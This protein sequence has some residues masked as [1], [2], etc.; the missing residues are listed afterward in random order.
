M[1]R[2]LLFSGFLLLG[3]LPAGA[4]D[5]SPGAQVRKE[6]VPGITNF[7]E[8]AGTV[9]C[10]GAV[11]PAAVAEVKKRGFKS[12]LDLR[13]AS[14]P[15]A[16]IEAESAAARE[17]GIEFIHLPFDS[18]APDPAVVDRFLREIA[19]KD[20][21]PPFVHCASGSRA[22]AFWLVK[23]VMLDGWDRER[24]MSEAAQLGTMSPAMK[25]FALDY[26]QAH[27]R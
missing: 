8:V 23:R 20:R 22:S 9:G 17:A 21:Q 15:G 25:Q 3:A 19:P 18:H 13:L 26:L 7:A 27:G 2:I 14:E 1:I 24:A 5:A 12:I 11:T 10:A 4:A 16:D 6:T